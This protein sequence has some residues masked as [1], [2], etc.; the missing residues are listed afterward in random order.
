[1]NLAGLALRNLLRRRTRTSL[2]IL[3]IALA[4]GSALALVALSYSIQDST[5]QSLDEHGADLAVTQR[6]A[7]DIFGGFLA[8]E[9]E[10]Q[11]AAVPG[12][13]RVT[14]ELVLFAPSENERHVLASGWRDT[15]S[16]W[17]RIPMRDGRLP[18]AGE[19]NVVLLG[20]ALAEATGKA[21]GDEIEIFGLA[22]KIIGITNYVS[23]VNRSLVIMPLSDL[24]DATYRRGQITIFHVTLRA[25]LSRAEVDRIRNDIAGLG[26]L[27]VSMT[28]EVLQKDRNFQTLNAISFVISIIAI[29]MAVMNVLNTLLM[30]VQERT[31]EIGI[32]AAIGWNDRLI[33]SSI[34]IEGLV[35]CAAGCVVGVLLGYAASFSFRA[36]P[37]IGDYIQF[38]PS[39]GLIIPTVAAAFVLCTIGAL[40]PAWR[41]VRMR[42]AE[43]L[44]RA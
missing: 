37:T 29:A 3:G 21:I 15:S 33:M 16:F 31:R 17:Q 44:G 9:M 36:V 19:N 39:L 6:G 14:G 26:K 7:P 22:F 24:Q 25:G 32:V 30:T 10:T 28:S 18:A 20:D 41:A 1:M 38:R 4:V 42:P 12:V 11:I 35:M 13:A 2:S 34:V 23:V 5:R 8:E 43:A 40:Y 27:S